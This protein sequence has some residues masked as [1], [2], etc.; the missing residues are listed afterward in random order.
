MVC[1]VWILL[2]CDYR[3]VLVGLFVYMIDLVV[4]FCDCLFAWGGWF[5]LFTLALLFLG[6]GCVW[7]LCF[8]YLIA[9]VGVFG[10]Y[11]GGI[12]YCSRCFLTAC[13]VLFCFWLGVVMG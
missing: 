4:C 10:F 12:V 6:F 1:Y 11:F 2:L 7:L 13:G 8:S 5:A 9:F 3:L